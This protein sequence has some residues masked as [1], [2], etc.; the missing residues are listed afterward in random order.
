MDSC[1]KAYLKHLTDQDQDLYDQALVAIF[2]SLRII[3]TLNAHQ[4]LVDDLKTNH[5][6]LVRALVVYARRYNLERYPY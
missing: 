1:D 4:Q 6:E 5:P 3:H 2:D